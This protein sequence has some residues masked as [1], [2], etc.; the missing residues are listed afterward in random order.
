MG[1]RL[2]NAWFQQDFQLGKTSKMTGEIGHDI[3]EAT[4]TMERIGS[5]NASVITAIPLR[6]AVAHV[7]GSASQ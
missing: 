2:H 3:I 7:W 1:L 4:C 5:I 6:V